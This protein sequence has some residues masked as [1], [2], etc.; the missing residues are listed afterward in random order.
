MENEKSF[1]D[2]C[3]K[4]VEF[5]KSMARACEA[6]CEKCNTIAAKMLLTEIQL[7]TEKHAQILKEMLNFIETA[8]PADLWDYR[9]D[10]YV[11][12]L[13]VQKELER[14]LRLEQ[15]MLQDIEEV[16]KVT[17]D[18]ALKLLLQHIAE[19]EKKHHEIIQTVL[20]KSFVLTK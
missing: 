20:R 6:L 3:R 15:K 19:D 12:S 16:I 1:L 17:K 4:H 8:P 18:E 10:S 7:D 11:D 5:E 14:H 2:M 13:V 9:I